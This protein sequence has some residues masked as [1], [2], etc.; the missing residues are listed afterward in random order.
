MLNKDIIKAAKKLLDPR[1]K[2]LSEIMN[3]IDYLIQEELAEYDTE[4]LL[5][6]LDRETVKSILTDF[7]AFMDKNGLNEV[8]SFSYELVDKYDTKRGN[9]LWPLRVAISG[10]KVALPLF[11]SIEILGF[12]KTVRRVRNALSKLEIQQ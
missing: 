4:L 5:G 11:E 3:W 1:I 7:L 9:V 10:K 2:S 8:S 12:E 6:K